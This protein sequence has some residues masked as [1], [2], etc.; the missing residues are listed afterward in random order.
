MATRWVKRGQHGLGAAEGAFAVVH[1]FDPARRRWIFREAEAALG[2][3]RRSG[4]HDEEFYG[5][6]E[7]TEIYRH[8]ER[9]RPQVNAFGGPWI[10]ET[11]RDGKWIFIEADF[12]RTTIARDGRLYFHPPD[13]PVSSFRHPRQINES[14]DHVLCTD[15]GDP[16]P[17]PFVEKLLKP[18]EKP[19]R[20]SS[21]HS[22]LGE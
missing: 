20:L 10:R 17:E 14:Q 4:V 6:R 9:L 5:T 22:S 13:V 16:G 11:R 19:H 18:S 8:R 1:P 7:A 21:D 15:E 3:E 12:W 2:R